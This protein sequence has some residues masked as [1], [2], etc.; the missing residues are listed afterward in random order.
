MLRRTVMTQLTWWWNE[1]YMSKGINI[2]FQFG[3]SPQWARA[4]SLSRLHD[5]TQTHHTQ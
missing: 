2:F 3:S 5:H 4:P 1:R